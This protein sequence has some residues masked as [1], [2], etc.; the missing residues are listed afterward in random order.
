M[1]K[2][3]AQDLEFEYSMD[4]LRKLC[5]NYSYLLLRCNAD[6]QGTVP[7]T[8]VPNSLCL[9]FVVTSLS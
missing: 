9:Y 4:D 7:A 3:E 5:Y 1:W 8:D 2:I 6:S